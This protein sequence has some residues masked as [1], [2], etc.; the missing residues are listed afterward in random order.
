[1]SDSSLNHDSEQRHSNK[2]TV[3]LGSRL[4]KQQWR[5]S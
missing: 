5:L 3:D 1:M 2:R 4:N